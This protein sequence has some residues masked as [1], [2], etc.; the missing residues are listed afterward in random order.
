MS[1]NDHIET[2]IKENAIHISMF[3][4]ESNY[5]SQLRIVNPFITHIFCLILIFVVLSGEN[6]TLY[7]EEKLVRLQKR[8]ARV[9]LDCDFYT[10]SCFPI[11]N[12][13]HFSNVLY[14]NY[15]WKL[16]KCFKPLGEMRLNTLDRI[17]LLR[18]IYMQDCYVHRLIS[19]CI[20]QIFI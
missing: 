14:I 9:I 16:F 17:L 18:L 15:I 6:C 11:L 5:I 8:A 4:H 19:S 10:P 13:C 1:W 2:V 3:Y 7:L 20:L 12:G